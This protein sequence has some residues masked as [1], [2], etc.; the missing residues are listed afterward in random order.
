[1]KNLSYLPFGL[2]VT[3]QQKILR[4]F[5]LHFSLFTLT[6][7]LLTSSANAHLHPPPSHTRVHHHRPL[8]ITSISY[9]YLPPPRTRI[10][11][12]LSPVSTSLSHPHQPQ[13]RTRINLRLT[14]VLSLNEMS[15]R[16]EKKRLPEA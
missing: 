8:V 7:L 1:M 16:I 4:F 13:P 14:L 10:N 3:H 11:L 5:I 12:S 9:L 2:L 6:S 15:A